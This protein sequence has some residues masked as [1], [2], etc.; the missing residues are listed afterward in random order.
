MLHLQLWTL[1]AESLR[2]AL[3]I[4]EE[5]KQSSYK[6]K[7][8]KTIQAC[9]H[10]WRAESC[11]LE[12]GFCTLKGGQIGLRNAFILSGGLMKCSCPIRRPGLGSTA[13]CREFL[14]NHLTN[15]HRSANLS[16][17]SQKSRMS[18]VHLSH[19]SAFVEVV[20][21]VV[22]HAHN[23]VPP[24]NLMESAKPFLGSACYDCY[25]SSATKQCEKVVADMTSQWMFSSS[26]LGSALFW[27]CG[28]HV[29]Q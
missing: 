25:E 13:F 19:L 18:Y 28:H 4:F 7:C 6:N 24:R 11:R 20:S 26:F 22:P 23:P 1:R 29:W 3:R 8:N 17:A 14:F 12:R 27:N 5:A 21:Q 10:P 16:R 9:L 2:F 15:Q